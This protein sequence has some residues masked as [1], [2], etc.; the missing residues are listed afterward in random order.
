MYTGTLGRGEVVL[1][2]FTCRYNKE[3]HTL[4]AKYGL[5]PRLHFFN[6]IISNLFMIVMDYFPDAKS[7]WRLENENL[8]LPSV[9]AKQVN[10]AVTLLHSRGCIWGPA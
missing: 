1:I 2:K 9:I 7:V 6:P 4:L 3:A 10:K 8:P 5:A